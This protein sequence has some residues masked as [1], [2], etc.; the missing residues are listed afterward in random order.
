VT[1][2]VEYALRYAGLGWP[3]FPVEPGTKVPLG[4]LVPHGLLDATVDSARIKEWFTAAPNAGVA[5]RTGDRFMV[6]DVDPPAGFEV[7]EVLQDRY[8]RLPHTLTQRTPRGGCHY[9]YRSRDGVRNTASKVGPNIDVRAAGGYVVAEGTPGY[10][11]ADWNV[12]EDLPTLA[13]M[14]D[15]WVSA[16]LAAQQGGA[17][18]GFDWK[19]RQ[20]GR[21]EHLFK[22]AC[23]LRGEGC[24]LTDIYHALK[25]ENSSRCDPPL[26]DPE[27]MKAAK[28]A[29]RYRRGGGGDHDAAI[30]AD[31]DGEPQLVAINEDM[32]AQQFVT[33]RKDCLR[34]DRATKQYHLWDGTRW[35]P[36]R[37]GIAFHWCRKI[38]RA[39]NPD[40]K[41]QLARA[42]TAAGVERYVQHDPR[43][44]VSGDGWDSDIYLLNTPAGTIDLKTFEM[45][46]CQQSDLIT[47]RTSIAPQLGDAATWRQ[48]LREAC[49]GDAGVERLLQQLAGICCTGDISLEKLFQIYGLGGSGK[50]TYL[51]VIS[52]VLGDYACT[53][54]MD[55]FTRSAYSK[56]PTDL[57]FLR[58]A[59]LV[60]ASETEEGRG[61]DAQRVK[62]LT[63]GDRISARLMRQDFF[64]YTPTFKIVIAGNHR[65]VLN[66]VDDAWRRRLVIIP[67][68]NRPKNPDDTLKRRLRDEYPFVLHWMLAGL[69]D[70]QRNGLQ[71]PDRVAAETASYFEVSDTL[72]LWID[73]ACDVGATH[74]ATNA[75]LFESYEQH[76]RAA[77]ESAGTARTFG[78]LLS[79]RGF[80]RIK[81]ARGIRG[82]G[83]AGLR[84]KPSA[85]DY[86]RAS[87]G[88]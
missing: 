27:V 28:S 88:E 35:A 36:E 85:D 7:I 61:W 64:S 87:R 15:A 49:Q 21:N 80:Q 29:C 6:I 56:H 75:A 74:A 72:A 45:R 3:C 70:F 26:S 18:S 63:G 69:D 42:S 53:A 25:K 16:I 9:L 1:A 73:T 84:I 76:C 33:S 67:F 51:T 19:I 86:V 46:Q 66:T 48:F 58:G 55:T 59:R 10:A 38:V 52:E 31:A 39:W 47:K 17:S 32:L 23:S 34:F 82:R 77:G 5:L 62:L 71:I 20:G 24:E 12:M 79:Q 43:I 83:F 41:R 14:P 81:D 22:L 78:D 4:K 30:V 11:F 60:V 37:M 68:M 54:S 8:G 2:A 40:G 65:P 13:D 50:S 57:A 44:A